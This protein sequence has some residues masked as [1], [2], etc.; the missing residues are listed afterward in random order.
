MILK[1]LTFFLLVFTFVSVTAQIEISGIVTDSNN[2]PVE[3]ANTIIQGVNNS[4]LAYSY[5]KTDGSY[6]V[7]LKSNKNSY[8]ILSVNSLGFEKAIDTIQIVTNKNKYTTSF[9]L[10]EKTEQL[11]EVLLLPTEKISR[12]GRVTTLKVSAFTDGTEQT[13][14]DILKDLPGIEVLKD[15][16]I[17][18]HGKFIDKLLIEGEDMFDKKYQI[19]SKNLD[20]KVLDAVQILDNF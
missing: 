1:Y 6:L 9:Q 13:I 15:G 16:T 2:F 11:N 5:T 8:I 20:A 10:Q 14:E 17:K 12:E 19:L 18:A 4:I 3:G 7:K